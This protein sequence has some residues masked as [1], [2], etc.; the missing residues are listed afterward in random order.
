MRPFIL[1][2]LLILSEVLHSQ[3]HA[4]RPLTAEDYRNWK[5]IQQEV[6]SSDGKSVVYEIQPQR[7]DGVLIYKVPGSATA[8]TFPRGKKATVGSHSEFLVFHIQ[9]PLD[10]V[11]AAKRKKV[12]KE[13]MPGDSLGIFIASKKELYKYPNVKS[14]SVAEENGNWIAFLMTPEHKR[15]STSRS[16][17][18]KNGKEN[19]VLFNITTADTLI[20]HGVASYHAARKGSSV[21][22]IREQKDSLQTES[23]ALIFDTNT[24]VFSEVFRK[25]GFIIKPVTDETGSKYAFLFSPDRKSVV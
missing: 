8:D 14:Y 20:V 17:N 10:S 7:G 9:P 2:L 18:K 22:I 19:L 24:G 25:P 23:R 3:E 11:L 12:K 16:S 5:S 4:P 15:D 13:E 1:F 21:M 6:I